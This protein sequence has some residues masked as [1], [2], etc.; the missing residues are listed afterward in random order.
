MVA[1]PLKNKGHRV[2]K[3]NNSHGCATID[4]LKQLNFFSFIRFNY[5]FSRFFH[6]CYLLFLVVRFVAV[7]QVTYF[8]FCK[9][10]EGGSAREKRSAVKS[11]SF[12]YG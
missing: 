1:S 3:E 9:I 8:K 5:L 11:N 4:A 6:S 10:L 2:R 12:L 7:S